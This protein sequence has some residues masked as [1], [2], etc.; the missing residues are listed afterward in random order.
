MAPVKWPRNI[1]ELSA[2]EISSGFVLENQ[3]TQRHGETLP[4]EAGSNAKLGHRNLPTVSCFPCRAEVCSLDLFRVKLIGQSPLG[5][6]LKHL[7]LRE[8]L[9]PAP[10]TCISPGGMVGARPKVPPGLA[11]T[12][13][14]L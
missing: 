13:L 2:L 14:A 8:G 11:V 10:H 5:A 6:E 9:R 3:L 1:P 4:W 12:V 7:S